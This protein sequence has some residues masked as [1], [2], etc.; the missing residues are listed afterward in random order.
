MAIKLISGQK[1]AQPKVINSALSLPK[2][3]G[4]ERNIVGAATSALGAP[5]NLAQGVGDI[6]SYGNVKAKNLFESLGAPKKENPE[7]YKVPLTKEHQRELYASARGLSPE[8]LQPQG[9]GEEVADLVYGDLPL[10][11]LT[12]GFGSAAKVLPSLGK[13]TAVSGGIKSAEKLGFGPAGQLVG[14]L[15]GG[16]AGGKL[17]QNVSDF[18]SGKKVPATGLRPHLETIKREAYDNSERLFGQSSGDFSKT[19]KKFNTIHK[20]L[21]K[22]AQDTPAKKEVATRLDELSSKIQNGQLKIQDAIDWKQQFNEFGY[23][24]NLD[25]KAKSIFKQGAKYL[26]DFIKEEGSKHPD[27]YKYYR[28]GEDLTGMLNASEEVKNIITDYFKP[29]LFSG[30]GILKTLFKASLGTVGTLPVAETTKFFIRRP[31]AR[32][33]YADVFKHAIN[34]DRTA[35]ANSL[36]KVVSLAEKEEKL[37]KE[38]EPRIKVLSGKKL[39]A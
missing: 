11:A 38:N 7:G 36:R 34:N 18:Y 1:V 39:T 19:E 3:S 27:A 33:Y 20:W 4:L 22:G 10:I 5:F 8:S 25:P 24:S 12:G 17:A 9:F 35:A 26:N 32:K 14:G 37:M 23:E 29:A 31:E 21:N 28:Q 13:A 16:A 6:L 30:N 15:L 2:A